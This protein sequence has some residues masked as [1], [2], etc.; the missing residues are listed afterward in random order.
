MLR[1]VLYF[2]RSSCRSNYLENDTERSG[3]DILLLIA[4]SQC[5]NSRFK[6]SWKNKI[7]IPQFGRVRTLRFRK[8]AGSHR[9]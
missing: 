8:S 2:V 1:S 6:G 7:I 3:R 9:E 4:L 5:A